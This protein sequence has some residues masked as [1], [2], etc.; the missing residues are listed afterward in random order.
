MEAFFS[1]I[2]NAIVLVIKG[3]ITTLKNNKIIQ[4]IADEFVGMNSCQ[5]VG[6]KAYTNAN[7]EISNQV[8]CCNFSYGE[9]V[10]RDLKKLK[11]ATDADIQAIA[12]HGFTVE[13]VIEIIAKLAN[14]F[15]LN[16]NKETASNQS[17][18]QTNCYKRINSG[19]K[20][21]KETKK[22]FIYA[23][24]VQKDI[25]TDAT[26]PYKVVKNGEMVLCQNAIRKYFNFS[27]AKYRNFS[28]DSASLSGVNLNGL[29]FELI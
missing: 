23:L 18:G 14:S 27:T 17:K 28:V 10:K 24:A 21:H 1:G 3:K 9:A 2:F 12:A 22:V 29:K 19:M 15:I 25:L 4:Q 16:Q 7:G 6:I 13:F 20:L 8:V 26:I 5:F 11:N